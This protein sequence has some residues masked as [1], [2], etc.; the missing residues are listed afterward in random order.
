MTIDMETV[1]QDRDESATARVERAQKTVERVLVL[2]GQAQDALA[3]AGLEVTRFETVENDGRKRDPDDAAASDL[4]GSTIDE[5]ACVSH[6][7][8]RIAKHV[9]D[10][11]FSA[12]LHNS[13]RMQY[14]LESETTGDKRQ[15][16]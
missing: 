3:Q 8:L 5:M 4:I 12:V 1:K 7:V 9:S 11:A 2:I 10:E 13:G 16:T 14:W 6:A 15:L